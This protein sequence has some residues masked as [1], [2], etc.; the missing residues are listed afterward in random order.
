MRYIYHLVKKDDWNALDHAKPYFGDTLNSQGFIHCCEVEQILGV[1]ERY[2]KGIS[3]LVLLCI[4]C[5]KVTCEIR[6]E[7]LPGQE[8][9]PHIY[10]PID[11]TAIH[12]AIPMARLA[13]GSFEL[14]S[15]LLAV[16][17]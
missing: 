2:F 11:A 4:S 8:V 9:F 16:D 10:G 6:Y 13:D 17:S 14:P 3:E 12:A 15:E 7:G 1:L 5:D